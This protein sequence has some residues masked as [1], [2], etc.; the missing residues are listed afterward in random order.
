MWMKSGSYLSKQSPDEKLS[1]N[2]ENHTLIRLSRGQKLAWKEL[3]MQLY[4]RKY[5]SFGSPALPLRSTSSFVLA[6][7]KSASLLRTSPPWTE[8]IMSEKAMVNQQE[9]SASIAI[10]GVKSGFVT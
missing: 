1:V 4:A 7:Q 2:G 6:L 5:L 8:W 3:V 10:I 9:K